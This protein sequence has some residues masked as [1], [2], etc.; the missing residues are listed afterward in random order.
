MHKQLFY[1]FLFLVGMLAS[2]CSTTKFVPEG[3]YLLRK[4]HVRVDDKKEVNA[5]AKAAAK[6]D[7]YDDYTADALA[8]KMAHYVRQKNNA[9]IFG[10]WPLQLMVYSSAGTDTT[11]WVNR[12]MM[13]MGEAPV[14]FNPLLAQESMGEIKKEMF[15]KGFFNATVDTTMRMKKKKLYLTYHITAHE[16]YTIR[17]YTVRLQQPDLQRIAKNE[18]TTLVHEGMI[19]DSEVLDEE[20]DRITRMMR[21]QGYY[22]FEK[23][24]LH[25]VADSAYNA[26]QVELSLRMPEYVENAPDSLIDHL[27][28]RFV[29]RNVRFYTD[30]DPNLRPDDISVTTIEKDGYTFSYCG[31][32]M[33]REGVLKKTCP[34]VPGQYYNAIRVERAYS[35]LS[36]LGPVKFVD[37]SFEEVAVDSL[38][39]KIVLSRSKLNS[40]SAEVEGTYSAGDWGVGVGAGY[41]NRNLFR[42]A[43]ELNINGAF[44]Y[45]WRKFGGRAIEARA[46]ASI[47]FPN[48]PKVS[49]G[50]KYQ[51]RPDEFT[52]TIANASLSYTFKAQQRKLSHTFRFFDLSYVYLPWISDAFREQFLQP[53]NLLRYSYE[54]HFILDWSYYGNWSNYRKRY[55][56]RSYATFN[57]QVE[58]A[59]N[60]LYGLSHLFKQQ[61]DPED[62]SYRLFNIRYAQYVKGDF[63][64][65]AHHILS[66]RHRFVYHGGIGIA[67]PFGNASSIPFEKRYFSGGANSVRGWTARTLGPGGYRGADGLI[68]YNN[69]VGDIKLDLNME[70][71]WRVWSIIE[72]AAFTDAGNVWTIRDYE[73]QPHGVFHW[74]TFYKE[75]AWSYGVGLRLDFSFFVFRVDFG[76]KLYDPSRLY[77]DAKQWRTV[78]NGLCWKDDMTF[79]FAIGYPF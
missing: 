58:T 55:P 73:S 57:Y 15:N 51:K 26:H 34:I 47:R 35:E 52:R 39:C 9:E 74:D 42:G 48:A 24:Y 18:R 28:T 45:E 71:R 70:Y 30:Y 7:N 68:A 40:I 59:G 65:T 36:A 22:F 12:Q 41:T 61:P 46:E 31:K 11:K 60:L 14:I 38:D 75:I 43:E 72:L 5:A 53:S 20:R 27:F 37:I 78:P 1:L 63:D 3:A 2:S 13:K 25:F 56:Y 64:F 33:I 50:Y 29:I 49:V 8:S 21:A 44:S 32:K 54:D 4:M 19:F 77:T 16:P 66:K 69:Q 17:S 62:G 79:H 10:F 67:V 76:V 23:D 6:N